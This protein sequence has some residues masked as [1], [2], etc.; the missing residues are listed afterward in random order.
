MEE[1]KPDNVAD[2]PGLLPYA[3]NI[4]AP[5]IRTEN[6]QSWKEPRI[7]NVNKQFNERFNNLKKEYEKLI[8]EY[9]WNEL[10]YKSKFNFEP[11]IGKTYHLYYS[12][13]GN[14]FLSLIEPNQ[15]NKEH[16]GS[17]IYNHDNKWNKI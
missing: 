15:W 10:V 17:F 1:K 5:A 7:I 3:S 8:D 13:E 6:I 9:R 11:V 4:G 14:I 12:N 16:I 2:N